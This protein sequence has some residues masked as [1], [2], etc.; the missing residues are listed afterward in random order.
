VQATT[1]FIKYAI[2]FRFSKGVGECCQ[3]FING[4]GEGELI[5]AIETSSSC[6]PPVSRLYLPGNVRKSDSLT[7]AGIEVG[8]TRRKEVDHSQR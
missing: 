1:E 6:A 8:A 5:D 3:R 7:L 2:A 4:T